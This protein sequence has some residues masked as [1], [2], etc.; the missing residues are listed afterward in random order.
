MNPMPG[1]MNLQA[2]SNVQSRYTGLPK[3]MMTF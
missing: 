1:G 3:F 2:L